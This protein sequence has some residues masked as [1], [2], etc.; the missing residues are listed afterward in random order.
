MRIMVTT[1]AEGSDIYE[2]KIYEDVSSLNHGPA[3]LF[4][5]FK[6]GSTLSYYLSDHYYLSV[7]VHD[8]GRLFIGEF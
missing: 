6:N 4:I 3:L 7:K 5:Y 1:K 2:N 8:D